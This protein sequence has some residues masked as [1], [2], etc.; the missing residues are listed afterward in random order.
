MRACVYEDTAL[1][2]SYI[3]ET[4]DKSK[5]ALASELA[6]EIYGM[7]ILERQVQDNNVNMTRFLCLTNKDEYPEDADKVSLR[8]VTS[9]TP[10]ALYNALGIFASF[11]INVLRLE[12]RPIVGRVFD[13]C[14][15]LDFAGNLKDP[16]VQEAL[17]RL[18]YD[19][20]ELDVFGNYKEYR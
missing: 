1:S 7:E 18:E 19:C 14:F 12:S 16:N 13:Y 5:A 6:A 9:H 20:I 3:K 4:G 15:Y 11:S 8:M 10:G 17:R 2:V